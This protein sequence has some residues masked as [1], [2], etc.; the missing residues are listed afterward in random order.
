MTSNPLFS[1]WVGGRL[2]SSSTA[3]SGTSQIVQRRIK[4][5]KQTRIKT[6]DEKAGP[7]Y[8][9]ALFIAQL[10]QALVDRATELEWLHGMLPMPAPLPSLINSFFAAVIRS[11][12]ATTK[13]K[14]QEPP[15]TLQNAE[16][17]LDSLALF[18]EQFVDAIPASEWGLLLC[19]VLYELIEDIEHFVWN[20]KLTSGIV[21]VSD[22]QPK[23]RNR[24]TNRAAQEAYASI[25]ADHMAR[26]GPEKFPKPRDVQQWLK[27]LG[28]RVADRTLRD[29]KGQIQRGVM[30]DFVQNR[31]RQ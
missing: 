1:T 6:E 2:P 11:N 4:Q 25:V 18:K 22:H 20:I 14:G 10:D 26:H 16:Q 29:W 8:F 23:I 28:H 13:H 9:N 21:N 31:K 27:L 24:P 12:D 15:K 30:S 7:K 19:T 5:G 3:A 17:L